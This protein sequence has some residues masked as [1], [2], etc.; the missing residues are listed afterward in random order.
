MLLAKQN[1][2]LKIVQ[3]NNE[4]KF[5]AERG[6]VELTASEYRK[7]D[8]RVEHMLTT[9]EIPHETIG[10]YF[11]YV[12]FGD[13]RS[14]NF[15]KSIRSSFEINGKDFKKWGEMFQEI[16]ESIAKEKKQNLKRFPNL[17]KYDADD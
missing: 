12:C 7:L 2:N 1:I 9:H 5:E 6:G 17:I 11:V 10:K 3:W 15:V 4:T 16:N 14:I 8:T 13:K